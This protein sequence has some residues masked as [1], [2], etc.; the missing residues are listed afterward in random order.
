M[1][2]GDL[3]A[4]GQAYCIDHLKALLEKHFVN[5]RL[6]VGNVVTMA[7]LADTYTAPKLRE[8]GYGERS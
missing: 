2:N 3:Q 5:K 4:G 1:G 6:S 7:V 8:V